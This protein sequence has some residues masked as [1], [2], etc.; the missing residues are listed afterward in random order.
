MSGMNP[1]EIRWEKQNVTLWHTQDLAPYHHCLINPYLTVPI[2]PFQNLVNPSLE[3]LESEDNQDRISLHLSSSKSSDGQGSAVLL[4]GRALLWDTG[5]PRAQGNAPWSGRR[6]GPYGVESKSRGGKN[7][8]ALGSG[9]TPT[10]RYLLSLWRRTAW[11]LIKGAKGKQFRS[12]SQGAGNSWLLSKEDK[13][14]STG[15]SLALAQILRYIQSF[16]E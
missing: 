4:T 12:T 5:V 8:S 15:Q 1:T 6:A 14:I 9:T 11:S 3:R 7:S 10:H 2:Q 16:I 13:D